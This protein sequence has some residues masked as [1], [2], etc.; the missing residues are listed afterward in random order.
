M[1]AGT[2]GRPRLLG[3]L[4]TIFAAVGLSL[5]LVGVYGVVAY[6][7][8]QR[9]REIG[10]RLALGA[11]P[12]RVAASVVVQGVGY[13]LAGLTLG[14]PAAFVLSRVMATL[15]FGVTAHGS[16]DVRGPT[17]GRRLGHRSRVLSTGPESGP[18]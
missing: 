1:I 15:V 18:H 6:R 16:A 8:R 4:L 11:A 5:G 12:A 7:I 2:L 10:I 3:F 17:C 13:A 9:E 14:L